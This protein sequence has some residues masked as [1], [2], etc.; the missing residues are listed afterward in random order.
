MFPSTTTTI[1]SHTVPSPTFALSSRPPE[2]RNITLGSAVSLVCEVTID[3]S[4]DVVESANVD[5]VG[6]RLSSGREGYTTTQSTNGVVFT[7]VLTISEVVKEDEGDYGCGLSTI[8]GN[9]P[10]VVTDST[11]SFIS[12]GVFGKSLHLVTHCHILH[13][14]LVS[15]SGQ[16]QYISSCSLSQCLCQHLL[17]RQVHQKKWRL[18]LL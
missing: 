18:D 7:G 9:S 3:S 12:L 8:S 5:W 16:T 15:L 2:N 17:S 14:A 1:L 6:P 10:H 13:I 11:T 4:Y